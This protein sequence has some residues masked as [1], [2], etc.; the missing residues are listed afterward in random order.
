MTKDEGW[1]G[2]RSVLIVSNKIFAK[3]SDKQIRVVGK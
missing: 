3:M 1:R 2:S